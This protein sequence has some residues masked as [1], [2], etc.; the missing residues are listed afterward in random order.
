MSEFVRGIEAYR[1]WRK[2][3]HGKEVYEQAR[4]LVWDMIDRKFDRYSIWMVANVIRYHRHQKYGPKGDDIKISNNH[5]AYLARELT[6][7]EG[8]PEGFFT[9]RPLKEDGW[10]DD[11]PQLVLRLAK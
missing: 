6:E 1:Q 9:L 5:L 8:L 3:D 2:T 4:S 7:K 11:E 10:F